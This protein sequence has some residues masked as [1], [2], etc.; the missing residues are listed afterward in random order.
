M[1]KTVGQFHALR[2]VSHMHAG[3]STYSSP[4]LILASASHPLK[5]AFSVSLLP[6]SPA[7]VQPAFLTIA[8][9]TQSHTP[10]ILTHHSTHYIP[11]LALIMSVGQEHHVSMLA[12][13][14]QPYLQANQSEV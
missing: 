3:G 12:E 4:P 11:V 1:A 2:P 10:A 8:N 9:R 13:V 6:C 7:I 5:G 14:P